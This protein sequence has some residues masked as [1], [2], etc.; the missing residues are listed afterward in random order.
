MVES[1]LN[2]DSVDEESY[3]GVMA[4][5]VWHL[6]Q[7]EN[8]L[9]YQILGELKTKDPNQYNEVRLKVPPPI[10]KPRNKSKDSEPL[11]HDNYYESL[12]RAYFRMDESLTDYYQE[13]SAA[14][15]HFKQQ[16]DKFYAIRVLDQ[17]PI[18]N[19]FSFI[20]SQNNHISRLIEILSNNFSSL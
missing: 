18:E 7:D 15:K 20:C 4:N 8:H 13:W 5:C 17:D 2:N 19:L 10:S 9:K 12:L 11:H 1:K 3:I 14:H 6:R 16:S